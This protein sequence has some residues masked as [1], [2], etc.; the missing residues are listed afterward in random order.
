MLGDF[1]SVSAT[2]TTQYPIADIIDDAT[3]KS[4]GQAPAAGDDHISIT[5]VLK[6][7]ALVTNVWRAGQKASTPGRTVFLWEIDGEEGSIRLQSSP[8]SVTGAFINIYEPELYVNG[9]R[10]EVE[11]G[12]ELGPFI[13]PLV[14]N[15]VEYSKGDEGTHATIEDAARVKRV[16]DAIEESIT[17]GQRIVV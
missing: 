10:V 9:E 2:A 1:S 6:S 7:G 11:E 12:N 8:G 4:I 16:L 14:R 15:W 3:G 5:G 17:T 13:G